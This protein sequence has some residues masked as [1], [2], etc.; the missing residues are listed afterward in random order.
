MQWQQESR[1]PS[2]SLPEAA[3]N[4]VIISREINLLHTPH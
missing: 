4:A 1:M 2:L 3:S